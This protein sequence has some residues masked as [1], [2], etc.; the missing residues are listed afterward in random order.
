[1]TTTVIMPG[2]PPRTVSA[3]LSFYVAVERGTVK[4]ND[5]EAV[6]AWLSTPGLVTARAQL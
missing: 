5:L 6:V 1:M 2:S 3:V 4:Y